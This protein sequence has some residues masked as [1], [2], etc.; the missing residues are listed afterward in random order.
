MTYLFRT[1]DGIESPMLVTMAAAVAVSRAI[2][3]LTDVKTGIKWVNDIFIGDKKV[4]GILTEASSNLETGRIENV[5]VGIGINI[6]EQDFPEDIK[7]IA[8]TLGKNSLNRN[9]LIAHVINWLTIFYDKM[10]SELFMNDYIDRCFVVGK[11]A[12]FDIGKD[13]E[14]GTICGINKDGSLSISCEDGRCHNV[15][16]GEIILDS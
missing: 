4:C 16:T 14:T 11:K 10:D 6:K 3:E 12:R 15:F 5:V 8:G 2:E 7:G 13:K 1:L 9:E